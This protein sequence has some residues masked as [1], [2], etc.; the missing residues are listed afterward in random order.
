MNKY[1]YSTGDIYNPNFTIKNK[2]PNENI[3]KW[4]WHF[5]NKFN[6]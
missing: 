4:I 2:W 6:D 5:A 3:Q 1:D